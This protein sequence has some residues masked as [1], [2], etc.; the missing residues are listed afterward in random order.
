MNIFKANI[1]TVLFGFL[2]NTLKLNLNLVFDAGL[3]ERIIL[4]KSDIKANVK[5]LNFLALMLLNQIP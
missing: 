2:I 5:F 1:K 3:N 4:V